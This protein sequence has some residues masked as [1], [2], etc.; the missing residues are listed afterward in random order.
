MSKKKKSYNQE[1]NSQDWIPYKR[2][3]EWVSE[4][5]SE[6]VSVIQLQLRNK[7]LVE[8]KGSGL[9]YLTKVIFHEQF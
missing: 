4:W 8:S 6:C 5:V 7:H 1:G 3:S 2:V 9:K